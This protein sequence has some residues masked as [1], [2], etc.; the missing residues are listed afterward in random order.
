MLARSDLKPQKRVEKIKKKLEKR[1]S[2]ILN[3]NLKK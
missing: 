1:E 3:K 2:K